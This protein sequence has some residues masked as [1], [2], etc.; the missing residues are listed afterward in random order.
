MM[1]FMFLFWV[2]LIVLGVLVAG[3]LFPRASHGYGYGFGH[4]A[5]TGHD[6]ARPLDIIEMRYAR[7]EV[8]REEFELMRQDLAR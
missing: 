4:H 6:M 2:G 3:W 1:G 5:T 7:G 8:T